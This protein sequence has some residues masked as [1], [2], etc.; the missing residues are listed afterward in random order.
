MRDASAGNPPWNLSRYAV[1][2]QIVERDGSR[3]RTAIGDRSRQA[4]RDH[5]PGN[6][7]RTQ[8]A[9]QARA[10]ADEPGAS[11]S[12]SRQHRSTRRVRS[13]CCRLSR[14]RR[15]LFRARAS[16]PPNRPPW[17]CSRCTRLFR[18]RIR[19]NDAQ[20]RAALRR[21]SS[22]WI[23]PRPIT[24]P[25]SPRRC[26]HLSRC[27]HEAGISVRAVGGRSTSARTY[28][29]CSSLSCGTR[30]VFG[31]LARMAIAVTDRQGNILALFRTPG[32]ARYRHRQFRRER[33]YE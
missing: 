30:R 25:S 29:R 19:S 9:A 10:T 11:R 12:R 17:R 27:C 4:I 5:E 13:A 7:D 20:I 15:L 33:G 23:I 31:G 14:G 22:R 21:Y 18:R 2:R 8:A 16:A 28:C 6:P 3:R 24:R 1:L 32:C 26:A